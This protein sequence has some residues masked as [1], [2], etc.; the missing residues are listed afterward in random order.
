MA[1]ETDAWVYEVLAFYPP[2]RAREYA[3]ATPHAPAPLQLAG[4]SEKIERC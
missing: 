1:K 3:P 4:T 2:D